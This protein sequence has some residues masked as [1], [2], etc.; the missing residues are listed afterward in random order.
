[1]PGNLPYS[2]ELQEAT[3]EYTGTNRCRIG[4]RFRYKYCLHPGQQVTDILHDRI[5]DKIH[6]DIFDFERTVM[7]PGSKILYTVSG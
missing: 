7:Q 6:I 2:C 3:S 5:P 4:Y 1:M